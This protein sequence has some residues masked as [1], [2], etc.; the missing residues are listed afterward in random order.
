M[1]VDQE[2]DAGP[3]E[4]VPTGNRGTGQPALSPD[5]R[6]LTYTVFDAGRIE[7]YA[8]RFPTG[9]GKWLV[10]SGSA[11]SARWS[12]QGDEIFYVDDGRLMAVR[13]DTRS[14]FRAETPELLFDEKRVKAIPMRFTG[15]DVTPDGQTFVIVQNAGTD[16]PTMTVVEN[17]PAAYE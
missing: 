1:Y 15:F 8:T 7:V 16:R 13:V 11:S 5:G 14:G 2:S 6:F 9:E 10:A 3:T 4:V 17:W 12:D